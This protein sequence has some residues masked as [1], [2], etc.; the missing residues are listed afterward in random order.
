MRAA[1]APMMSTRGLW[2]SIPGLRDALPEEMRAVADSLQAGPARHQSI[3]A[4]THWPHDPARVKLAL[5]PT[6]PHHCDE[7][8][9]RACRDLAREYNTRMQI[10]L[11]ES[12]VQAVANQ[13]LYG[14]S[15]RPSSMI[16]GSSGRTSWQLTR[17][18]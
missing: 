4:G 7:D 2:Q 15:L 16:S 17:S 8:F 9:W 18:G 3:R 5:G 6:I 1:I 12:K 13:A 11:A 10:H 14:K